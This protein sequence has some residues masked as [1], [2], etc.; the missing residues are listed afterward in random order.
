MCELICFRV[1]REFEFEDVRKL[2]AEL[3]GRIHPQVLLPVI[4]SKLDLAVN[5]KNVLKIK[6]FIF[7]LHI[8]GGQSLGVTFPSFDACN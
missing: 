7:N 2:S 3:C 8:P 4:C 5:S 1:L 6:A